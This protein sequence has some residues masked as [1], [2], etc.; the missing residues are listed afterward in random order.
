MNDTFM[1]EVG[2]E[3]YLLKV[4]DGKLAVEKGPFV[5]RSWSFAIRAKAQC[6]EKFWQN[7]RRR[8]GTISSRSCVAATS[9]SKAI[10]A[11]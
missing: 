11:C 4:T 10:S 2:D 9:S 1:L 5:M 7:P 3:Q 8:A 6:W